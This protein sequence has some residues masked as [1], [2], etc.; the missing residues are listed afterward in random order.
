[1]PGFDYDLFVIGGGSGGVRGAR[2]AAGFGA[3]VGLAEEKYLGGTC[4]NVG[5]VPKKLFSY[6]S[7]FHEEFED[8]RGFGWTSGEVSFDWATLKRNKDR[9]I[10]RLND[11][12]ARMLDRAEVEIHRARAVIEGPNRV[13]VGDR[14]YT[15]ANILVAVGGRPWLPDFPGR[16]HVLVSD[17]LFALERLPKRL[18]IAGGGYIACEFASIFNGLGL[19]VD[20]V[21][22]GKHLLRGFDDDLR[23]HLANE[24]RKKGVRIH[25]DA[26]F[27]SV[28]KTADGVKVHLTDGDHLAADAALFAVGRRPYTANLGLEAAGVEVSESG[29]IVVDDEFR[30]TAPGIYAVGDV[31]DR[32]QLT[33]VALAEGMFV[34]RRLF[35]PG[36]PTVSYEN[37]PTAVFTHPNIGT[38]GLTEAQARARFDRIRLYK[39]TFRPMKHTLSGRDEKTFM[40]LV[41]DDATDRVVGCHMI[42]PDAGEIVQGLAVALTCGATKAQFDATLGIH[43]TAAEEFVTMRTEWVPQPETYPQA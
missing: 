5:C 43:P 3:R 16:E 9:E 8:A 27:A 15:A 30:T 34:A 26:A 1:M 33:P 17:D 40:K 29:A 10:G 21:Y 7:H 14:S 23:H 37:I 42:G 20:L 2:I 31:I 24:M 32:V 39:S 41:V 12:Y 19:E 18:V 36:G 22:R 13:R 11:V 4:V 6:A 25:F 28:E 35:G 38:V